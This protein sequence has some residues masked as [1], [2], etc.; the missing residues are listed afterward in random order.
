MAPTLLLAAVTVFEGARAIVGDGTVVEDAVLIVEDGRIRSLGPRDAASLPPGAERVS[1]AGKTIMPLLID[2]HGH[3]GYLRDGAFAAENYGAPNMVEQLRILEYFGVGAFQSLGTDIGPD[4][5]KVRDDQRAGKLGG[6]RLFVAGRGF[7]AP[8]G[9]PTISPLDHVPYEVDRPEIARLL[10]RDLAVQRADMIKVWVD[11]RNGTRPKLPPEI[12]RAVIDEAH[13]LGMRVMAHVYYLEDA[14]EL[15]RAGVDGFAHMVRDVELDEEFLRLAKER[16]VFQAG[17]LAIQAK[18]I[19]SGW[20]D[21]PAF[22]EATPPAVI[23]RLRRGDTGLPG[24]AAPE[25][26]E[27]FVSLMRKNVSKLK[28]AGVPIALGGDTGIPTRFVGY[29]EHLELQALV[30]VG[31]TPLEAITA[32][33]SVGAAI[34]RLDDLGSL[35]TGKSGDFLVLNAN[36]LENI[37]NT[38]RIAAVYRK[39][40]E[41]DRKALLGPAPSAVD[42]N[43]LNRLVPRLQAGKP[44]FGGSIPPNSPTALNLARSSGWDFVWFEMEHSG[45]APAELEAA[46]SSLLDRRQIQEDGPGPAVV[47]LVRIPSNGR[48]MNEWTI[49]H[50]LDQGVFG[51]LFPHINTVEEA[52]HAVSFSRYAQAAGAPDREPAGHRGVAPANAMRFWGIRGFKEYHRR[53]DVW[54]LDPDGELLVWILIEEEEGARNLRDILREVPVS[55]VIAAEVDLSTSLGFPGGRFSPEVA[56]VMADIVAT[57]KEFGVPVGALATAENVEQRIKDG[58]QILLTGDP[59]AIERGRRVNP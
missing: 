17:A 44:I 15:L 19:T 24:R 47:P 50:V 6:A 14:K 13:K 22:R 34:L 27:R 4:A 9:G 45:F 41:V 54:P 46:V 56:K 1:L 33:T 26:T 57:C 31:L 25:Q 2:I 21:D 40:R 5:W 38:T 59:V 42:S 18:P 35:T 29:N 10:V 11:D 52:R 3:I 16:G 20:L 23:E 7:V 51:I 55:G 58:Y 36:P 49:K 12:Y 32:G 53:A 30:E 37:Q 28:G 43:R 48:E 39:G 8:G